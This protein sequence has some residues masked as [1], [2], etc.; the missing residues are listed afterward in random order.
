MSDS[1]ELEALLLEAD[2]IVNRAHELLH[3]WPNAKADL[4]SAEELSSLHLAHYTSLEAIVYMLQTSDGGLRLSHTSI[5]NDPEE[6]RATLEGRMISHL[7]EN[8][9]GDESWLWQRYGA[10]NVCCFVGIVRDGEQTIDAGDDLLFW[11]LYGNDCRGISITLP[12]HVSRRLVDSSTVDCVIYTDDPSLEID[13]SLFSSLLRDLDSLRCRARN[14][15]LWSKICPDVLAAC[16]PLLK[17]RFLRKR[18]HYAI[19][20]EYRVVAFQS[21]DDAEDVLYSGGGRHVQHGLIRNYIQIPELSCEDI[22][23]TNSQITIGSNV[24]ESSTTKDILYNL[25]ES[26]GIVRGVV[27][28]RISEIPYRPR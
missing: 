9:F 6:G 21:E 11:R 15:G 16:D 1:K 12:P 8:E 2:G 24:L 17:Q 7:L 13:L 3:S 18:S 26:R 23:T 5:M 22:L 10:A 25:L 14:A 19:E 27:S 20:R 4:K 28:V